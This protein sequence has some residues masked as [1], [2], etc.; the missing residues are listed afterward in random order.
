[1][2]AQAEISRFETL[3]VSLIQH[4]EESVVFVE[5]CY[6]SLRKKQHI[7]ISGKSTLLNVLIWFSFIVN[8]GVCRACWHAE[9]FLEGNERIK[10]VEE[11]P[12]RGA[13]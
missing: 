3:N 2:E 10:L 12:F 8:D 6:S 1:M 5:D 7:I 13:E 4:M 11:H 9:E